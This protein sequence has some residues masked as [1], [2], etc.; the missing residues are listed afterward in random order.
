MPTLKA[1]AYNSTVVMEWFEFE[2]RRVSL[3]WLGH[4]YFRDRAAM[5]WGLAEFYRILRRSS[6]WLSDDELRDLKYARDTV[7][8][9]FHRFSAMALED[10]V[11]LYPVRPKLHAFDECARRAQVTRMSPAWTWTFQDEDNMDVLIKIAVSCHGSTLEAT[12]LRTWCMQF[13]NDQR[14]DSS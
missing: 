2:S 14:S 1:K 10:G 5:V 11:A 13:F 7:L 6:K 9:V 8:H 3:A 4:S 12:T